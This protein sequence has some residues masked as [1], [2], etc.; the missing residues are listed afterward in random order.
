MDSTQIIKERYKNMA[1][2][3]LDALKRRNFEGYFCENVEA[4]NECILSLIPKGSTVSWGGSMT[5]DE[6]GVK[7]QIKAGDYNVI[8]RDTAKT[9]EE[10]FDMMRQ[11]LL[12]DVYLASVNAMSEDGEMVNIDAT[13][14]RIAAIAFGPKTVILVVGMNK[15]CRDLESARKRARTYAAPNNSLRLGLKLPCTQTG[16]CND[17]SSGDSV[18]SQIVEMRRNRIPGRIKVVLVGE[19]LGL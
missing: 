7:E 8:D 13:G 3:I 2:K 1:P 9:Q 14:N 10:R 6:M 12:S 4:A 18:C 11:A 17:C 15:I 5:F 19:N 16:C